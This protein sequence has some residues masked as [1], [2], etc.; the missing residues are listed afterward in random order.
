MSEHIDWDLLA[1]YVSG[2]A[3][4]AE[5][6]DVDR[7]AAGNDE[8]LTLLASV[9]RRW[10]AAA[11]SHKR[12]I[13]GA[14]AK[15]SAKLSTADTHVASDPDILA[16]PRRSW[17]APR[18]AWQLAA[19]IVLVLGAGLLWRAVRA[20]APA[21]LGRVTPGAGIEMR[22]RAGER[23][24]LDLSDGSRVTLGAASVLR[25]KD[26][27]GTA[28]R[29]VY[30]EGQALFRVTHDANR[31]FVVHAAG[32]ASED[33]GTEFDVR[34]YPGDSLVRVVVKEGAVAV[35]AEAGGGDTSVLR[36]DD[37]ALVS[38]SG[39]AAVV[40]DM[41][42]ERLL[43]W[44]GGEIVFDDTPLS[45][46][47]EELQRWFDIECRIADSTLTDLHFTTTKGL[48]S[49][50]LDEVLP[51][52]EASLGVQAVREGRIVTFRRRLSTVEPAT[53]AREVRPPD[54]RPPEGGV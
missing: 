27:F 44:T 14:W 51:V 25:V 47:A 48:R 20:P 35:H 10:D 16:L 46:V 13:D 39:H 43:A 34:A 11:L 53:R 15:L 41:N 49:E 8:R 23:R 29:H 3:T 26:D 19:A 24:T 28:G 7:W 22:T 12:D 32:T 30:L 37:V 9:R 31:R 6:A 38:G 5:R 52:I 18:Q 4:S 1:R 50:S 36:A 45:E 2:E 33:L 40:H 17:G 54:V 42:V 21:T